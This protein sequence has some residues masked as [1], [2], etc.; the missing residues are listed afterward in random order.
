MEDKVNIFGDVEHVYLM[1][2]KSKQNKS[3]VVNR[4]LRNIENEA[5]SLEGFLDHVLRNLRG[6]MGVRMR[7]Y[8]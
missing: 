3:K 7:S 8:H 4:L 6:G 5:G 1:R 2:F